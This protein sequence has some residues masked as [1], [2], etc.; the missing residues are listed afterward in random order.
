VPEQAVQLEHILKRM[1]MGV[2]ILDC[3]DL[4]CLYANPYLLS[5]LDE[6]WRSEGV[7]G[8]RLNEI[9]STELYKIMLP[10]L[11]QICA[12]G[13]PVIYDALAYEGFL[14]S[15][16]RT[17][18]KVSLERVESSEPHGSDTLL[19][20]IEDVTDQARSQL[21]LKAVHYISS[22]IASP[23]ALPRVLD[24]I[25]QA[26]HE[27]VGSTRCAVLLIDQMDPV[28]EEQLQL[29][30]RGKENDVE[31]APAVTVAAQRGIH[32]LS[33]DWRPRVSEQLLLGYVMREQCALIIENTSTVPE[34]QFPLL[35]DHG[36]PRRP[37]S[38][39]SVP[40]FEP[41]F[42]IREEGFLA[43]GKDGAA[44]KGQVLGTIDVYHRS[45]RGFPA[46]EVALLEQFARQAG[47]AIYNTRLLRSID[48][49]ARVA[50]RNARQRENVMQAIPDG[51]IIY[52]ARWRVVEFNQAVRKVLG[53]TDDVIGLPV[54]E[55]M[56]HAKAKYLND[57]ID[58]SDLIATL[59]RRA[60]EGRIDEL[61]L[62]GAD[63][64]AYTMRRSQAPI[65]DELGN[66]FAFVV[67]YHDV[68][69]QAAARERIEIEVKNRTAELAQ[70]NEALQ[71]A[72][73]AQELASK[74]LELLL[75]RLPSGVMLISA[76]DKS[77]SII[78]HLH[79]QL[80]Q[81]MGV[82][83]GIPE[84]LDPD[85]AIQS[86]LGRNIEEILRPLSMYRTSGAIMQYEE[87]PLA[88]ALQRGEASEAEILITQPDGQALYL[89]ASAAPL[90]DNDGSITSVVSVWHDITRMKVL[91][92]AREDF[93][94]TLAHEL[95]TPL[96][97]IR[98]HLSALQT[99]DLEWTVEEQLAFL[100]TA[101]EQA[102]RLAKMVNYFLDAS[103]VEAGALRLELEP[104]LLPELF[105]DLQDR[106]LALIDASHR[107]LEIALPPQLP[108][109]MADYELIM[110][111]L[112]NL[113]SNAFRYAPE[114]DTV[115]IE[116]EA[117]FDEHDKQPCGVE[118][119][120]IDRG[121][122]MT[123]ERQA[124]LFTR[125]STFAS[126]RRPAA[127]RPGQPGGERRKGSARWS[128]ATGL[129]LYISKGII[130]AH[131]SKLQVKSSP[132][133]GATFSFI[134]GTAYTMKREA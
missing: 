6:P 68:T 51:V 91:E 80:L 49:L 38:V 100:Q 21:Y 4:G 41:A 133:E 123:Q 62:I 132:G 64:E 26:V 56:A 42:D 130:E 24:R 94:T 40:I 48:R 67:V 122:G 63:G 92:R 45:S 111:V 19:V 76:A 71:V 8:R 70:R 28:Y 60:L 32:L 119:R 120:V 23:Y 37:G 43:N 99:K 88:V 18:W 5:L 11:E 117:V 72:K 77:I 106:L 84:D 124:E 39:L 108:A 118:L 13:Q 30:G 96:A 25:L 14:Q 52:D 112:T 53:W 101:D 59:E 83:P 89:L 102:D 29:A 61:K 131:G 22:A 31:I 134:L 98:A 16:G 44:A 69:Q 10:V 93:F 7:N 1:Q 78:N 2:A 54:T 12:T 33:H 58:P 9:V 55:V 90:R 47:L 121:P 46:E 86:I 104:I 73:A 128:P 79:V 57:D 109:V 125:F 114:G 27:M 87:Q 129:G 97:N 15:R 116:A 74:R 127:D 17:Y 65:H 36:V 34:M 110:N 3:A 75:E 115:R 105:E 95:K 35:D 126:L 107:R 113:L 81:R 82:L 50:S 103:R 66:I 85:Q 20:T